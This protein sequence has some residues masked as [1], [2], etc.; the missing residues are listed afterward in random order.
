MR[1]I[2]FTTTSCCRYELLEKTYSSF[3]S[4]FKGVDFKNSTLFLNL[5]YYKGVGHA[6]R[7]I[8]VAK[9]FFGEVV[10]NISKSPNFA[11]A[12]KWCWSRDFKT[13]YVFHLEED[14]ELFKEVEVEDFISIMES[15]P[16]IVCVKIRKAGRSLEGKNKNIGLSPTLWLKDFLKISRYMNDGHNP[17]RQIRNYKS[18]A[19]VK[20]CNDMRIHKS[21]CY[22]FTSKDTPL[23]S[24]STSICGDIGREWLG[25]NNIYKLRDNEN[26]WKFM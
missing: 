13:P 3:S 7:S 2:T 16:T 20:I 17:E 26:K 10:P 1:P 18:D 22:L 4:K 19:R 25:K 14:W 12:V 15:D 24:K 21:Y 23:K 5:D 11:K 6:K 8:K 9:L